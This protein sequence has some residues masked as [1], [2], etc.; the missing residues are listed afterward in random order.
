MGLDLLHID[1]VVYKTRDKFCI[2]HP[3]QTICD[4]LTV[5]D[6]VVGSVSST[7]WHDK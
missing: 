4:C 5:L 7:D 1:L 3:W 6:I 2:R